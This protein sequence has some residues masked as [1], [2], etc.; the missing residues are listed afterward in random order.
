VYER[1]KKSV[2]D[3]KSS[4]PDT[5][6]RGGWGPR[7]HPSGVGL[8]GAPVLHQLRRA[9]RQGRD[10][11]VV[12]I[13]EAAVRALAILECLLQFPGGKVSAG[14][15]CP[16]NKQSKHLR[17][18]RARNNSKERTSTYITS[19]FPI[20]LSCANVKCSRITWL[21]SCRSPRFGTSVGASE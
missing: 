1:R 15:R 10:D 17:E 9:R 6:Q 8:S 12:G 21:S 3:G 13:L 19:F 2:C 7:R 20:S 18:E 11:G 5:R 14:F 16:G 4:P